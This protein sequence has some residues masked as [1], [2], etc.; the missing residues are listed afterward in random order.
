MPL[1]TADIEAS[2]PV[3]AAVLTVARLAADAALISIV[4]CLVLA[5]LLP[6][7]AGRLTQQQRSWLARARFGCMV[8]WPATLLLAVATAAD[9]LAVPLARA[10]ANPTLVVSL[11]TQTTLGKSLALQALV[12]AAFAALVTLPR[13]P[14]AVVVSLLAPL[15]VIIARAST[16]HSGNSSWHMAAVEAWVLH[17]CAVTTWVGVVAAAAW[18][19]RAHPHEAATLLH[20][21]Q[22]LAAACFVLVVASGAVGAAIRV[23]AVGDITGTDYGRLLLLKALAAAAIAVLAL[24]RRRLAALA[25]RVAALADV[26][27]HRADDASSST[28]LA[29]GPSAPVS[30]PGS[31]LAGF[32]RR[33]L[34]LMAVAVSAS[35]ILARTAPPVD[36]DQD[37]LTLPTPARLALGFPLPPRATTANLVW[38]VW[39]PEVLWL[40]AAAGAVTAYLLAV[41]R[42]RARGDAWS[43]G[44]TVAWVAGWLVLVYATSGP[45]GVYGHLLFSAHM[46]Q[47][48]LLVML[49]PILLVSGAPTTLTLRA[50]P[51][52]RESTGPREWLLAA[53]HSRFLSF[54]G[55]PLVA[56]VNFVAG[57]FVLYFSGLFEAL[58]SSHAGHLLM[59]AHFLATGY[60][61]FW[62]LIGVDPSARSVPNPAKVG[63]AILAAPFHAL[64]SVIIMQSDTVLASAYFSRFTAEFGSDPLRDQYTGAAFG[65]AFGEVP[66]VVV[67]AIAVTQW[68]RADSRAAARFDR[69][70]DARRAREETHGG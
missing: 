21:L 13:R 67:I 63:L 7:D 4:G 12:A 49:A 52:S 5:L 45:L 24:R 57:F 68:V 8:L 64:F 29:G 56:F 38:A 34:L 42:L 22:P 31:G 32:L 43:A 17:I 6:N 50:L 55:H 54:L 65:W 36:P 70:D 30:T 3:V 47:H 20:R 51:A 16:G 10:A 46:V 60:L 33:E 69:L 2:D 18:H 48:L 27:G 61:F 11:L 53:L 58:M 14:T 28:S 9:V 37:A 39:R 35:V 44:R 40:A 23:A 19:I 62:V 59:Q 15:T 1:L 41:R 26:H 25:P 66:M